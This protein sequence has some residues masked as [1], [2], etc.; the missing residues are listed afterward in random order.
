MHNK[1]KIH[2]KRRE[3]LFVRLKEKRE[4]KREKERGYKKKRERGIYKKNENV[5][6]TGGAFYSRDA[7]M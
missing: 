2:K 1:N 5:K 4:Y 6:R 3:L 7:I